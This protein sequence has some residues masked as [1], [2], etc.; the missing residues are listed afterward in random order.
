VNVITIRNWQ[1]EALNNN[2]KSVEAILRMAAPETLTTYRD[3]GTGW[4]ALEVLCHLRDLEEIVLERARLT[5]EQ[6]EPA[7]PTPD[8]DALAAE[9]RYNA[10]DV[11]AVLRDWQQ[12]RAAF[13]DYVRAQPDSVW[14]RVGM[15]PRR[16]PL[17]LFDQL[18]FVP[19]HDSI[20]IEQMTRL[21]REQRTSA[22]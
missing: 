5:V 21:L 19:M 6:D 3:G 17:T 11:E 22:P 9:R 1:Y 18:V 12:K 13:L 4:T 2:L 15:H 14:E 7:L 20:H 8:P 10:Q 16:G